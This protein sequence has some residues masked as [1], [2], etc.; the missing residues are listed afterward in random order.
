MKTSSYAEPQPGIRQRS[1]AGLSATKRRKRAGTPPWSQGVNC[2]S[3]RS[4]QKAGESGSRLWKLAITYV[5]IQ[6]KRQLMPAHEHL[7]AQRAKREG[8]HEVHDKAQQAV[9]LALFRQQGF[10]QFHIVFTRFA[11]H[12]QGL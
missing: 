3:K 6:L 1:G 11:M 8:A 9:R 12:R 5:L 4:S 2:F 7:Q 10:H